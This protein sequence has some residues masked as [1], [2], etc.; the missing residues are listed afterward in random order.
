[1]DEEIAIRAGSIQEVYDCIANQL[2][3]LEKVL[4]QGD[5]VNIVIGN[6]TSPNSFELSVSLE[7]SSLSLDHIFL[8]PALRRRGFG[9]AFF[10]YFESEARKRGVTS[11]RYTPSS[12]TS[13]DFDEMLLKNGYVHVKAKDY[14]EKVL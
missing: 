7:D 2:D 14:Y 3:S 11:I 4:R 12:I 13:V 1:M 6:K 5:S 9:R 10:H 8:R